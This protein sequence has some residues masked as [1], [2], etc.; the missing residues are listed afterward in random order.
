MTVRRILPR[1]GTA[2]QWASANPILG[3]GELGVETDTEREKRGDGTTVWNLLPYRLDK[4]TAVMFAVQP[5][6]DATGA[7]DTANI[8]AALNSGAVDV[9]LK[10]GAY[11]ITSLNIPAG[12]N[13]LGEFGTSYVAT[14]ALGSVLSQITGVSDPAITMNGNSRLMDVALVGHSKTNNGVTF[15]AISNTVERVLIRNFSTGI[16]GNYTSVNRITGCNVSQNGATGVQNLIDSIIDRCYIASNTGDGIYLGT[17]AN[18]NSIVGNKLE[19][20]GSRNLNMASAHRNSIVGNVIDR[21]NNAGVRINGC[22]VV[23]LVGNIMRR[24]GATA[25][26]G[27]TNQDDTHYCIV[28]SSNVS[29]IGGSTVHGQNDSNAGYD[30]PR[31]TVYVASSTDV[32]LSGIPAKGIN[33]VATAASIIDGGGNVNVKAEGCL[34][35][36]GSDT[37][38]VSADYTIPFFGRVTKVNATAAIV[39]VTLPDATSVPTGTLFLVVKADNS[40]NGVVIDPAGSQTINGSATKTLTTQWQTIRLYSDG[41]NWLSV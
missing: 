36:A 2:A 28:N 17:G 40:A 13:L 37:A 10:R 6:G 16:N 31:A 12:V 41:T 24:N 8:Q 25:S 20:N 14:P 26:S 21:S 19:F 3:V 18:D 7:T 4:Q 34:L 23:S 5:S 30:S 27:T 32:V 35:T 11:S 1:R 15:T 39:T 38:S 33:A 9:R 22:T 29:I